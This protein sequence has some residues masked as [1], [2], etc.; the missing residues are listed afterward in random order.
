MILPPKFLS[1]YCTVVR[2]ANIFALAENIL[3]WLP[4]FLEFQYVN[5]LALELTTIGGKLAKTTCMLADS[6]FLLALVLEDATYAL[7]TPF[8]SVAPTLF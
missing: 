2:D 7:S 8:R 1:L 3:F 6:D 5:L 4:L